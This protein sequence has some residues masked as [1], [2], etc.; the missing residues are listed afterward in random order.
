MSPAST[1]VSCHRKQVSFANP[2]KIKKKRK[3]KKGTVN[4]F[5]LPVYLCVTVDHLMKCS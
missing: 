2:A 4:N 5:D 3:E 1:E